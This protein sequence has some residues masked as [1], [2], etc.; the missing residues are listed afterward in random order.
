MAGPET[1]ENQVA[2]Q[3]TMRIGEEALGHALDHRRLPHR[4]RVGQA[5]VRRRTVS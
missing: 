1:L 3:M 2:P 5:G 4:E